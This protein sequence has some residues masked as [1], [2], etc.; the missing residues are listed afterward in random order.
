MTAPPSVSPEP[1]YIAASAA[2]QIVTTDHQ[3]Q[4]EN[5]FE[6]RPEKADSDTAIVSPASLTLINA[7][8]DQLLYSFLASARS[9]SIAALRPAVSEVLKPRLARDAINGADQ[10]LAEFLGGGDAEELS[11]F[12]NGLGPRGPWDLQLVWRRTRLRCMVYTR[13]GDMEEEDEEAFVK[14]ERAED[15]DEG[16]RRLSRDLGIV[17][18][19]A[20]IFLTSILEFIGEQVLIV[21]GEAAYARID[22][23]RMKG[24]AEDVSSSSE[25][26]R[27]VV[28]DSDMEKLAFSTTFGRLWR[29]WK[30]R[31][32]TPSMLSARTMSRDFSR[33]KGSLSPNSKQAS[34]KA[35]ID[36]VDGPGQ[37]SKN[38]ARPSVAAML[39]KPVNAD[40]STAV[41]TAEITVKYREQL[42]AKPQNPGSASR[43]IGNRPHSIVLYPQSKF[44]ASIQNGS[45]PAAPFSVMQRSRSSSLPALQPAP[46]ASPLDETFFNPSSPM[47]QSRSFQGEEE[48]LSANS[49]LCA[50]KG[51]AT[52][53]VGD[54]S[55]LMLASPH[56]QRSG[57]VSK[58]EFDRQ[59]LEMVQD[60]DS[61]TPDTA[62]SVTSDR[63]SSPQAFTSEHS[64]AAG[65]EQ[66]SGGTQSV[67]PEGHSRP[68]PSDNRGLHEDILKYWGGGESLDQESA[69]VASHQTDLEGSRRFKAGL[70]Q[71]ERPQ[72]ASADHDY[73]RMWEHQA[74]YFYHGPAA[75]NSNQI[76]KDAIPQSRDWQNGIPEAYSDENCAPPLT[77]LR[78][79]MEAAHDTS[80]EASSLAPSHEA[81]K[82]EYISPERSQTVDFARAEAYSPRVVSLAKHT[83]KCSDLRSKLPAV[84]TGTERAAVQRVL[85][86]PVSA[87]EPLTP[88]PRTSTSSN[89]DLRQTQTSSSSTSQV[90]QKLKGLVGRDSSDGRR[91][92]TSRRSSEGSSSIISDKRSLRTP[93]ADEAQRNFDQLIKSDETIQYTLTPQNMREMEVC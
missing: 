87:R 58:E 65:D 38:P 78:E 54:D 49:P 66:I 82:P 80:D 86:S 27:V 59:M 9:T 45:R 75:S 7:F 71:G 41:S 12:H 44:E 84:N 69:S 24:S 29:S 79:L 60:A 42:G 33:G 39:E 13:L 89:R 55:K 34:R 91:P 21:A 70:M 40:D 64:N 11:A 18:P 43:H 26:L 83:S 88:V 51:H 76:T 32:R 63:D 5:W 57:G 1:A 10:E 4:T 35:S 22:S 81:P 74:P 61:H 23:R 6:D 2:S 92:T 17:S 56:K 85:P 46:Y 15:E 73:G 25:A 28:E 68:Q 53:T 14:M 77:P 37:V 93:K 90:S 16:L 67:Q 52:N 36:E 31:V 30:K 62:A 8:L 48:L 3:T 50:P 19:A 72:M 20:A 47:N